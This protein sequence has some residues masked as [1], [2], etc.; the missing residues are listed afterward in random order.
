VSRARTGSLR[1]VRRIRTAAPVVAAAR[2]TPVAPPA[3]R[4]ADPRLARRLQRRKDQRDYDALLALAAAP[5]DVDADST[6]ATVPQ[7]SPKQLADDVVRR[8]RERDP[9]G[10]ERRPPATVDKRAGGVDPPDGRRL[11]DGP[12]DAAK[13]TQQRREAE[14]IGMPDYALV[15]PV[16]GMHLTASVAEGRVIVDQREAAQKA[17]DELHERFGS[18]T[19]LGQV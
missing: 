18:A 3:R 1:R 11:G 19:L 7:P 17:L 13:R 16:E 12:H 6:P 10:K 15:V 4:P 14:R 5:L 9:R 8:A 2:S